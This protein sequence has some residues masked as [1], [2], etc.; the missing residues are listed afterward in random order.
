MDTPGEKKEYRKYT[1]IG[2]FLMGV[3][4]MILG[5]TYSIDMEHTAWRLAKIN[6]MSIHMDIIPACC[7][8]ISPTIIFVHIFFKIRKALYGFDWNL[9]NQS[10]EIYSRVKLKANTD[11]EPDLTAIEQ[12]LC[13]QGKS[14]K[15][16]PGAEQLLQWMKSDIRNRCSVFTYVYFGIVLAILTFLIF[17]SR[18][19]DPYFIR[20]FKL[21]TCYFL[22]YAAAFG[23]CG[24]VVY[25]R[26]FETFSRMSFNVFFPAFLTIGVNMYTGLAF[27]RILI[28]DEPY[29]YIPFLFFFA[30]FTLTSILELLANRP[31]RSHFYQKSTFLFSC[32]GI[33]A[34]VVC[35]GILLLFP[36][37]KKPIH[38]LAFSV[39]IALFFSI[40]EGWDSINKMKLGNEDPIFTKNIR[41]LNIMQLA[42]PLIVFLCCVFVKSQIFNRAFIWFYFFHSFASTSIWIY[43]NCQPKY[44]NTNWRDM[45]LLFGG[46]AI[47]LILISKFIPDSPGSRNT[48]N[49]PAL[50]TIIL[51]IPELLFLLKSKTNILMPITFNN[52]QLYSQ[53]NQKGVFCCLFSAAFLAY[54]ILL[55]LLDILI[56]QLPFW[57]I[58]P[59]EYEI[60]CLALLT[61]GAIFYIIMAFF[62]RQKNWG[63]S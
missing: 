44:T 13:L 23:L 8:M 50:I 54:C 19:G 20:L 49:F 37:C 42:C 15:D 2:Y 58:N 25:C 9:C 30:F 1:V 17:L 62:L 59:S 14:T 46:T 6:Q 28:L 45:K 55:Y 48:E 39:I 29:D 63:K 10:R 22:C 36:V 40:F 53:G 43:G 12:Y 4:A 61:I 31:N 21:A 26:Y 57:I 16:I 38:N 3:F 34:M 11:E 18:M 60:L 56:P 52:Y 33:V 41:Y 35:L 27:S 7:I 51:S 32:T 5:L 47:V 24:I